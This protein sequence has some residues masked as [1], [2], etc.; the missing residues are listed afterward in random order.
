MSENDGFD[1]RRVSHYFM[2]E[3]IPVD[4]HIRALCANYR[5]SYAY[6][7]KSLQKSGFASCLL[8]SSVLTGIQG[9]IKNLVL[10]TLNTDLKAHCQLNELSGIEE[11]VRIN[12]IL[13]D[14]T[15]Q[16][17]VHS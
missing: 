10:T 3:W 5:R 11:S 2:F 15:N 7:M 8:P 4:I 1:S 16:P 14:A 13:W 9:A 6:Q 17:C 12:V